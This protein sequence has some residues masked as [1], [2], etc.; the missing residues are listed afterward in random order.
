MSTWTEQLYELL[1]KPSIFCSVS[2]SLLKTDSLHLFEWCSL[3]L[4]LHPSLCLP[5]SHLSPLPQAQWPAQFQGRGREML[6]RGTLLFRHRETKD[7]AEIFNLPSIRILQ[8]LTLKFR[9]THTLAATLLLVCLFPVEHL[10]VFSTVGHSVTSRTSF[11]ARATTHPTQFN[12]RDGQHHLVGF[13]VVEGFLI[14]RK[15]RL[16]FFFNQSINQ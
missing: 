6:W 13:R 9:C 8:T 4:L 7:T 16:Y 11:V 12:P 1:L 14:W 15:Q 3:P 10:V 2:Y 5:L